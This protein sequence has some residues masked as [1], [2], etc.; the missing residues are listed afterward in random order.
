[1]PETTVRALRI[2]LR[3]LSLLAALGGLVMIVA[4]SPSSCGSFCGRPKER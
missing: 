1:M 3:M 4:G 2:L